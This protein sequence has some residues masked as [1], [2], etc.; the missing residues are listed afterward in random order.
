VRIL[1]VS[2]ADNLSLISY[3]GIGDDTTPIMPNL[4]LLT[5]AAMAPQGVEITVVDEQVRPIDFEE[6]WDF[7]GITGYANHRD[8]M[9]EIAAEFRRRGQRVA[10][11]GPFATMLPNELRDYADVLFLGEAERTWPVFLAD[12]LAGEWRSEYREEA[13]VDIM[14]SPIPDF[15]RASP[16]DYLVGV[17]Q[18]SRGCPFACDFCDVIVYLGRHQRHKTPQR[19]VQELEC[20]YK[21]GYRQV[22]IADDNFTAH[23]P[24]AKA[25][26]KEIADWNATKPSPIVWFTQL[27]I[28]AA[29]D[30]E[31]LEACA[32]AGLVQAYIGIETWNEEALRRAHKRQNV[33]RDL[34][35]D[36]QAFYRHGIAVQAGM[37]VG[38]DA[39]TLDTFRAQFEFLQAAGIPTITLNLLNAPPGTPLFQRLK[40]KGRLLKE[41][42]RRFQNQFQDFQTNIVPQ[43]MTFEQ[44]AH[45]ACW[46]V[47]RLY[48]PDAF[49]ARLRT[50]TGLLPDAVAR[51]LDPEEVIRGLAVWNG[52][53]RAQ[54]RLG[55]EFHKV[56]LK[57]MRLFR[58]KHPAL[59]PVIIIQYKHVV[60]NMHRRKAWHPQLSEMEEPDFTAAA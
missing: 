38:F 21:L 40:D 58:G 59:L 46:L 36:V 35:A 31:L 17:V 56:A 28:D 33:N 51:A 41:G 57:A 39:D 50:F 15:W 54:K 13:Q 6:R 47:N 34:V 27:S 42:E 30:T 37:I 45:G 32:R 25:I 60:A 22:F 1:L 23:R 18:A 49:L 48:S 24:Q 12:L 20:L 11:G 3:S 4:A 10:I 8:R 2:P 14:S 9:R 5:L 19:I 44:L 53:L 16:D 43:N 26:L 52:V 55:P 29:Q 7:V